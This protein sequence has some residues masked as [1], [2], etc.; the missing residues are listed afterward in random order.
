MSKRLAL[1]HPICNMIIEKI[2]VKAEKACPQSQEDQDSRNCLHAVCASRCKDVLDIPLNAVNPF[3]KAA[4]IL[5]YLEPGD[6]MMKPIN[7]D[8]EDMFA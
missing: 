8:A 3:A 7:L 1:V 2:R 4:P 5:V 6:W